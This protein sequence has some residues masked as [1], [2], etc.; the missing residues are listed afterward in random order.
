MFSGTLAAK[1]PINRGA[2]RKF[3]PGNDDASKKCGGGQSPMFSSVI[4]ICL[5]SWYQA[6]MS[7]IPMRLG[8][9]H[10]R[11]FD[12]GKQSETA[13]NPEHPWRIYFTSD[14]QGWTTHFWG[15]NPAMLPTK[16]GAL[17]ESHIRTK[18]SELRGNSPISHLLRWSSMP[19]ALKKT[20]PRH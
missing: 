10:W 19:S 2:G 13:L 9:G 18:K 1:A 3:I 11:W 20:W 16:I 14:K 5:M 8:V 15:Q 12:A 4:L 6:Y 7:Y 17:H